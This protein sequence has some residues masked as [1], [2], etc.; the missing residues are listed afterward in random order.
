MAAVMYIGF[1]DLFSLAEQEG[2]LGKAFTE[3]PSS[4]CSSDPCSPDSCSPDSC[5][6][7]PLPTSGHQKHLQT[8]PTIFQEQK[9]PQLKTNVLTLL[10][11]SPL[12]AG[13]MFS[14]LLDLI[15]L[16]RL[17]HYVNICCQSVFPIKLWNTREQT[18]CLWSLYPLVF[19][20][21]L[22]QGKCSVNI[23]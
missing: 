15:L 17:W 14:A 12:K 20:Q 7:S 10:S 18:L 9:R 4:N 19:D 1:L 16:K 11:P 21:F 5:S 3:E 22:E 2:L 6:P 13:L 8:L 23:R